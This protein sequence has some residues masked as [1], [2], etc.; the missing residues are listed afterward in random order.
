MDWDRFVAHFGPTRRASTAELES[1]ERQLGVRFPEDYVDF[2]TAVGSGEGWIG[3][4]L[5]ALWSP[6]ELVDRNVGYRID[7]VAEDLPGATLFGSDGGGEAFGF[8][9]RKHPP[10]VVMAPFIVLSWQDTLIV[11]ETFRGFLE[12][13]LAMAS[14][15]SLFDSPHAGE[16]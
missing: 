8:D 13:A 1:A 5:L 2:M 15:D 14:G 9:H 4:V 12:R 7:R 3:E 16:A 10:K 11:A 6:E